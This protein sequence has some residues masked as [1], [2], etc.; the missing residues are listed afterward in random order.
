[1]DFGEPDAHEVLHERVLK[2]APD[3]RG[4]VFNAAVYPHGPLVDADALE[5][6]RTL[7]INAVVPAM[8]LARLAGLPSF[9]TAVMIT[10][11]RAQGAWRN[12]GPY[13]ASKAAL[14]SLVRTAALELAPR[15]R[16][17]GVAPGP[18]ALEGDDA[19]ARERILPRLPLGALVQPEDVARMVCLLL[20]PAFT[21]STGSIWPVDAGR[22]LDK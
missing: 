3:L 11:A 6:T 18:I 5:V 14:E 22:N 1:M 17:H 21:S 9:Q 8:A 20:D 10:D 7:H 4:A 12:R 13:L 19:T 15:V 16:V 2:A